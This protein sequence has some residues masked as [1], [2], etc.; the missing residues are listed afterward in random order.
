MA[1]SR[2]LFSRTATG[3]P[4]RCARQ[5][6]YRERSVVKARQ[7]CGGRLIFN[8]V[9]PAQAG[10]Q[11]VVTAGSLPTTRKIVAVATRQ[12]NCLIAKHDQV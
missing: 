12:K 7:G 10:I 2:G 11:K 3:A 4:P 1:G 6:M 8:T 5:G 9:I